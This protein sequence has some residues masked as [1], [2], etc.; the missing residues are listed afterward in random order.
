MTGLSPDDARQKKR[1]LEVVPLLISNLRDEVERIK[2]LH[3]CLVRE[4]EILCG[5][6]PQD[7][8]QSN[9][10][11]ERLLADLE[12]AR[13]LRSPILTELSDLSGIPSDRMSVP[14]LISLVS[15]PARREL[16]TLRQVLTL[17]AGKIQTLNARNRG[18]IENSRQYVK[19]WLNF[20]LNTVSSA[21]CYAKSGLV[22]QT[23]LKGRFFRTEG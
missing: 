22:P 15:G 11:K 9:R 19:S 4:R 13:S 18:L 23:E 2:A 5:R 8:L 1:L 6:S 16:T 7:L 14:M 21:P 12:A 3:S 10:E 20:L 17:L